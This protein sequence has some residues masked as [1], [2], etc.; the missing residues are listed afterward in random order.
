MLEDFGAGEA[1]ALLFIKHFNEKVLRLIRHSLPLGLLEIQVPKQDIILGLL[2]I[3]TDEGHASSKHSIEDDAQG[4][5][6]SLA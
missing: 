3:L 1:G 5:D 6:I 4:P 2:L